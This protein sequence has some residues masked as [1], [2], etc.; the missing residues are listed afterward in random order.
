[1]SGGSFDYLYAMEVERL[2]HD[3]NLEIVEAMANELALH[4]A[5]DAAIETWETIGKLKLIRQAMSDLDISI[6]R[7]RHVWHAM[8]WW[9]S[10]DYG[11]DEF[12]RV[13]AEYRKQREP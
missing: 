4:E 3:C 12:K 13:L 11:E 8:E 6:D 9:Q 7:L 2:L 10:H 5:G 1:M